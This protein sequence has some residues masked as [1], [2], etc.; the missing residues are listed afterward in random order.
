MVIAILF[1][2]GYF[3]GD[4]GLLLSNLLIPNSVFSLA[5][6][7]AVVSAI[8]YKIPIKANY[9]Y[10]AALLNYYLLAATAGYLVLSTGQSASPYIAVWMLVAVFAGLFGAVGLGSVLIVSNAVIA[11][12]I[13]MQGDIIRH[14]AIVYLLAAELP[15]LVS[16][17][18]WKSKKDQ[19]SEKDRAFNA[20]AAE[21]TEV[22]DKSQ[23]VINA[24][25][26]G[27]I[28]IDRSGS[29]ELIN[30]AAQSIIGWSHDDA[31]KLNYK[32]V[33]KL[34]DSFSKPVP[35][36]KNPIEQVLTTNKTIS[37]DKL[38]LLTN[39]GK[40]LLISL[41]VSPAGMHGSG[42]IIVFRDITEQKSEEREQ[43]EF[44]STASHEMRTPVAAIE[45]YLGLALNPQTATIDDKARQF[46]TKAHESAQHLGRLFQDLL[47]VTKV[48][49]GRLT[50]ENEIIDATAFTRDITSMF[51]STAKGKGL[52]LYFKPG[53]LTDN[54]GDLNHRVSPVFY[55]KADADH[56]REVV[57]NLIENAIKYTPSGSVTV[58]VTGDEGMVTISV[59]DSGI[60]IP[61]E[62]INHLFQ[63]FYR[64]DNSKTREIG[65]TGL[66]LY[67]CRR[68]VEA[69]KGS[70]RVESNLNEGSTF[71][72]D[73]AR[74][75]H[76]K[77]MAQLEEASAATPVIS[78]SVA[79][80][81]DS[82]IGY[83]AKPQTT[84]TQLSVAQTTMT[85][86][87]DIQS[88][89]TQPQV[90]Q[91]AMTQPPIDQ[92]LPAQPTVT[93]SPAEIT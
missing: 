43:A 88:P 42:A 91:P 21:L 11:Y 32:S 19:E 50:S 67:L 63:K 39:S 78:P 13:Y 52:I 89:I 81:S 90:T 35:D 23:I 62:D 24:I 82:I 92:P 69:M 30:P 48:D 80:V 17:L 5:I 15:L 72:V 3:Q 28:A 74:I 45:G 55:I 20:L 70:I 44:I 93:N 73:F 22:S 85:Q 77:A 65:G 2:I 33:L 83:T 87:Q 57:S 76:E 53:P 64:I 7:T 41:L 84:A 56:L 54:G 31:I 6:G 12:L 40:Q 8:S 1:G 18:I 75:S 71:F 9:I 79:S 47:D 60:G 46:I 36:D 68:L 86:P 37:N 4:E 16:Y 66:G 51:E 49:D 26:D 59:K 14:H 61:P 27:V 38:T 25:A 10:S 34:N 58:D 29:I